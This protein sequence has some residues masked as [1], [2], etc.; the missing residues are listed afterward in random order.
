[1]TVFA[2]YLSVVIGA[3]SLAWGF[4]SSGLISVS[5]WILI[6]GA[7]WLLALQQNWDWVSAVGLLLAVIAATFGLALK[8]SSGW[9][10]SGGLFALFA[11]DLN[12][13]RAR[14]RLVVKDDSMRSMERRH[15]MRVTLL[16]LTGLGLASASM[17]IIRAEFTLEWTALLVLIVLLGLAQLVGW[18]RKMQ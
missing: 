10:F 8:I 18:F 13:F 12:D 3:V 9:M 5:I 14:M 11:W 15:I 1:M 7:F 16:A 17:F 4:S 2:L 6:F